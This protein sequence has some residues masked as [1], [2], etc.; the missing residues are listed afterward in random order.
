MQ[1]NKKKNDYKN[2][3]RNFITK[4]QTKEA[5][6]FLLKN[7]CCATIVG[8]KLKQSQMIIS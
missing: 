4:G 7:R 8:W 5:L 6:N 1:M 3:V 2:V